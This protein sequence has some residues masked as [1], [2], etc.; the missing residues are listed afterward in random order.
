MFI[1]FLL[2]RF[3]KYDQSCAIVYKDEQFN[4]KWL[5]KT[6][7]NWILRLNENGV[8][9][10]DVVSVEAD[11][12]PDSIALILALIDSAC[13]IVPLSP[14]FEDKKKQFQDIAEVKWKII[15]TEIGELSSIISTHKKSTHPILCGLKEIGNPG[16]V[17]F[18]S[19]STG[20]SKAAVH[21]F[22][23]LLEKFKTIRSPFRAIAFLLFDHIG[24]VNTMLHVLS[25]G[26]CLIT[27]KDRTPDGVCSAIERHKVE[28]LPTS[29]T[30]INL[31]LLSEA[32]K[33]HDLSS[34]K[35]V[36]Y[37]TEVMP[38]STLRRF[39]DL[40]PDVRLQQTYGLSELG[41]LRSKSKASDSL[42]VKLGGEGFQ[43]RVIDGMLEIKARSA[44][45][46]YLNAPSPF[47]EDGWLK[48]GDSVIVDGEYFQILG[49]ASEIINVGGLKV[50]PAQVESTIQ[51]MPG[52]TDVVVSAV[53]NPITGQMVK[54][55]IRLST[56]EDVSTFRKRMRQFCSDKLEPY[57]I[58]QQVSFAEHNMYGDRFKKIRSNISENS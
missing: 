39:H 16:L 40:F 9:A 20:K 17:L 6:M 47:T 13:I 46:G 30:F 31:I 56:N 22:A 37:G 24:G 42:W 3:D 27:L 52:V 43:T 53:S 10:G 12:S 50:Y 4:Y 1:D 58:P 28:T 45:I 25:N 2:E 36:T 35:L 44:M 55:T 19:G 7:R 49:R 38:M 51:M 32:F 14:T 54:A 34:L 21:D 18:S 33:R 26:G 23:F 57:M 11:F 8:Y 5:A 15:L 41:I 48:T 29:P